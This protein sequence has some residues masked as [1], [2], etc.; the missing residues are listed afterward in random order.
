MTSLLL[1]ALLAASADAAPIDRLAADERQAFDALAVFL[2]D[3]QER[4][5]LKLKTRELRDAWLKAQGLYSRWWGLD[6]AR[7]EAIATGAV[8][9]GFSVDEV[10]MAWGAPF[11]RRRVVVEGVHRAEVVVYRVEVTPEGRVLIWEAGSKETHNAQERYRWI[12]DVHDGVVV[13]K[14][15]KA[16]WE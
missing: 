11:E 6:P 14:T 12:L 16:R 3:K 15:K 4:S 2:D 1:A 13:S 8:T 10:L 5:F 7:R 9:V